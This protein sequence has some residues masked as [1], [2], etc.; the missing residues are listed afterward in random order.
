MTRGRSS[1]RLRLN[2][3][4]PGRLGRLEMESSYNKM[5]NLCKN[6]QDHLM[7]R[8]QSDKSNQSSKSIQK[9]IQNKKIQEM[10]MMM[11][12]TQEM[13]AQEQKMTNNHHKE[14][15]DHLQTLI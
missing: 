1:I 5:M 15:E 11:E 14:E 6:H 8:I 9:I 4:A 7:R 3:I 12:M 2:T 10:E 13:I